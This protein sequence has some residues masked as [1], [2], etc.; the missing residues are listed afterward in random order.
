[1]KTKLLGRCIKK[2]EGRLTNDMK[3]GAKGRR[4]RSNRRRKKQKKENEII[5]N[6][7]SQTWD[8]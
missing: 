3:Y 7:Y 4:L 6:I 2:C 8:A 1:M 5:C